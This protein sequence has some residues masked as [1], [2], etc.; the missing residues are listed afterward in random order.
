MSN[1]SPSELRLFC[2]CGQKMKVSPAMYGKPGKCV[3]CRQK[4]RIPTPEEFPSGATSI[5]LQDHPEFLRTPARVHAAKP[6][7]GVEGEVVLGGEVSRE[8]SVVPNVDLFPLDVFEPLRALSSLEYRITHKLSVLGKSTGEK[9]EGRYDKHQLEGYL[10]RV[11]DARETLDTELRQRLQEVAV[12]LASAQEKLAQLGL[13]ARVSDIE[14]A[15]YA[16]QADKLRRRRDRL[17][18]RRAN[19]RGWLAVRSPYEAGG[20][21]RLPMDHLPDVS[22]R[23][24]FRHEIDEFTPLADWWVRALRDA[25]TQK[26]FAERKLAEA[27]RIQAQDR[28]DSVSLGHRR[29]DAQGERDRAEAN[30]LFC[31]GR[32]E[33]IE[34]D[35][36]GDIQILNDQLELY[37]SRL[38]LGEITKAQFNALERDKARISSE[39]MG[40]LDLVRRG[41]RSKAAQDIPHIPD[42]LFIGSSGKPVRSADTPADAWV[43]WV[44]AGLMVVSLFLP[45]LGSLSP[46]E[47]VRDLRHINPNLYWLV[48]LP[49]AG[50]LIVF[51]GAF[52]RKPGVRGA[53]ALGAWFV[54]AVGVTV[55]R[56]ESVNSIGPV[57]HYLGESG[58]WFLRPGIVVFLI[59]LVALFVACC[60]TLFRIQSG[61]V[62]V[63]VIAG[64]AILCGVVILSDFGGILTP[65]LVLVEPVKTFATDDPEAQE[66]IVRIANQGYRPL[67]LNSRTQMRN[68]YDFV[69]ERRVGPNLWE[70][71]GNPV[72]LSVANTELPVQGGRLSDIVLAPGETATFSFHIGPGDYRVMLDDAI[73]QTFPVTAPPP[74]SEE[75]FGPPE[76][77]PE[78]PSQE[79]PSPTPEDP[80]QIIFPPVGIQPVEVELRGFVL[81]EG[82]MPQFSIVI[83]MP[84]GRVRT[85][86]LSLQSEVHGD[87]YVAEYNREEQTVT[88]SDT[89]RYVILRLGRR[90]VLGD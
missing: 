60:M 74:P 27:E 47:A 53:L 63:P 41:L 79:V 69:V 17:E 67:V 76:E 88:L 9:A 48:L 10:A 59:A 72:A 70:D 46:V 64:G 19:L 16:E 31:R 8:G 3:A 2:I 36:V 77:E 12:E 82:R 44:A 7:S 1:D 32:L 14:F 43:L 34:N 90:Q 54:L 4:I 21:V 84:D 28:G 25:M 78:P 20:Y 50:A 52:S 51:A 49:L 83:Y 26:E 33:Q 89:T 23:V 55:F 65:R 24:V 37:R 68:A 30:I 13:S 45:V 6:E 22:S 80:S 35:L 5:S 75:P 15:V 85:R 40:S 11:R 38:S 42:S 56:Q 29:A 61:R 62:F 86:L 57:A 87:W 73:V 58:F 39:L 71:V 18:R 81:S 66:A